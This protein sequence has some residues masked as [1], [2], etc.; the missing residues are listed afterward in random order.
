M[1]IQDSFNLSQATSSQAYAY[2]CW[3]NY[4]YGGNTMNISSQDMSEITATW[5]G[6]LKN[7]KAT[8][9]KDENKYEI[10]DD[11]FNS[12]K[13]AGKETA[14]EKAGGFSGNKGG[15]VARGVV[16]GVAGV[17]GALGTT[18]GKKVASNLAGKIA[19]KA[20]E[21]AA[22]EAATKAATKAAEKLGIKLSAGVAEKI[23]QKA[24]E[25]ATQKTVEKT[26]EKVVEKTAEKTAE[27][28]ATKAAEKSASSSTKIGFIITAP[29]ALATGTMY[30]AKKPNKEEKEACDAL[31]D[32]MNNAQVAS[33]AAQD[34]ML[35]S[36]DELVA[37]SEEAELYNEEA[38]EG[39]EENKSELDM[40]KATYDALMAKVNS[41]EKLTQDEQ[42]LLK[43]ITSL[44]QGLGV[45]I[46][47]TSEETTDTVSEMYD[48][49]GTYQENFDVAAETIAEVEG[50]TD[51]AEGFDS[52]TQM[53]CYVEAAA[54]GLNAA[55]G[56]QA[57]YEASAHAAAGGLFGLWALP[58]AAAGAAGAAMSTTGVIQQMS[59]AG[60]VGTE[61]ELRKTAQEI[62]TDT[63]DQYSEHIDNYDGYMTTV[64]DLELEI[65]D[66][67]EVPE[68]GATGGSGAESTAAPTESSFGISP[69]E[70]DKDK[71]EK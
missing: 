31:Q 2:K 57:A 59:W 11:N 9:T 35:A 28:A 24:V 8:A 19:Q 27:N 20:M 14:Q 23:G 5:S 44:M 34:E 7:W 4:N 58:F 10:T 52:A 54:Q 40:Y 3:Y 60:D 61:I 29:L 26:T 30:M 43:S 71:E 25:K 47:E 16:D 66:E 15:M 69:K 50:L 38:N 68:E 37:L 51:Y 1:A 55:S 64:E 70:D 32:E 46:E 17:A 53:M 36:N 33:A 22:T 12:A 21:K 67:L 13:E 49:M 45:N 18:V 63:A 62:N 39:I 65:P 48:E 41:G 56:A 6:Q 42:D